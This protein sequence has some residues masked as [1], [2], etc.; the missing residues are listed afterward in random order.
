MNEQRYT[1]EELMS[2][3]VARL[4]KPN[5][6]VFVGIGTG[7]RSFVLGVGIPIVA[8]EF[9]RKYLNIDL[10][11]QIGPVW[12]PD[13]SNANT[14]I[15]DNS[16]IEWPASA[17]YTS[18]WGLD[19]FARGQIDV[20][21]VNAAQIDCFGNL[22]TV[23]IGNQD[24]PKVRLVGCVALT[25]HLACSKRTIVMLDHGIRTFVEEV[26]FVSGFGKVHSGIKR[27]ELKL[28]GNG[29]EK[30]IT[31]MAVLGFDQ[32]TGEIFV[33]YM[34]PGIKKE[35]IQRSTGFKLKWSKNVKYTNE[36]SQEEISFIRRVIDPKNIWLRV[37]R[38]Y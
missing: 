4:L 17:Q 7:V 13:I 28:L 9:A 10:Q 5:E 30:V 31:N 25:D 22:N 11:L 12:D 32:N 19:E 1:I 18:S 26:D 3:T 16:F 38:E 15:H 6:T 24:N 35:D 29:P 36:P 20:A 21:F 14:D 34:H 2:V 8:C 27:S 23:L 33:E 37:K